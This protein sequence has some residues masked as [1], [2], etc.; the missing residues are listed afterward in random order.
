M[1]SGC[2][3]KKKRNSLVV[4]RFNDYNSGAINNR[5]SEQQRETAMRDGAKTLSQGGGFTIG[6]MWQ[7]QP[8]ILLLSY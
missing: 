8:L 6:C 5:V 7:F 3:K 2:K 1:T 4:E